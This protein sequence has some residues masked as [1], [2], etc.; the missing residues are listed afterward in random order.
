MSAEAFNWA[1]LLAV[2]FGIFG[3]GACGLAV[4]EWRLRRRNRDLL[5]P[6]SVRCRIYRNAPPKP[7]S[8]WG[9]TR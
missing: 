1:V 9:S 8:R 3:V 7:I 5:P 2:W 4:Y 6:P